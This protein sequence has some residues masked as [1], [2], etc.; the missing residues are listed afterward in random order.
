MAF[1]LN[2]LTWLFIEDIIKIKFSKILYRE[3]GKQNSFQ[4]RKALEK[5]AIFKVS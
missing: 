2:L 1:P 3:S 4:T 5:A